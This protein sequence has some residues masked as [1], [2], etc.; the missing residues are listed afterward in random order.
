MAHSD[1]TTRRVLG[2]IDASTTIEPI[3]SYESDSDKRIAI[4]M[5]VSGL[6]RLV[7]ILLGL[8][9]NPFDNDRLT[10]NNSPSTT[11]A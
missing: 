10:A 7:D 4:G 6:N 5:S 8:A 9:P 2:E 3:A 11:K 1:F